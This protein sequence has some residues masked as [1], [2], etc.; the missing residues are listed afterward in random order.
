[1]VGDFLHTFHYSSTQESDTWKQ[2]P[3]ANDPVVSIR[4]VVS[5]HMYTCICVVLCLKKY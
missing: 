1:M 4:F 5:V 2:V 3:N